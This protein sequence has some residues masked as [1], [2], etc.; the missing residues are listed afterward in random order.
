M[1]L[2]VSRF[3]G[4][5]NVIGRKVLLDG[6]PYEVIGVLAAE[7]VMPK[8]RE[9]VSIPLETGD[10]QAWKP[11][12]LGDSELSAM[13]DFNF[14]CVARLKPG[15]TAAQALA[16]LNSVEKAITANLCREGRPLWQPHTAAAADYGARIRRA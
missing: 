6:S 11:F 4:D 13:G 2:W 9:L 3:Q 5:R 1:R 15:V 14:G 16:D 12:G 10:A 8:L 7:P